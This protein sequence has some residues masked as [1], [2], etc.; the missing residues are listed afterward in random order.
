[1]KPN[2]TSPQYNGSVLYEL[3]CCGLAGIL[4][5]QF[6]FRRQ[7]YE[8]KALWTILNYTNRHKPSVTQTA[9][10]FPRC[11]LS[12]RRPTLKWQYRNILGK[13]RENGKIRPRPGFE[14]VVRQLQCGLTHGFCSAFRLAKNNFDS[15]RFTP[16]NRFESIRPIRFDT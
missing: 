7:N 12:N 15:I 6:H 16:E 2:V 1:M 9:K 4:S 11:E 10:F 13:S 3:C 8:D 14:S 5:R